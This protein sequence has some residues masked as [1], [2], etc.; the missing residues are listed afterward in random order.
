MRIR[1]KFFRLMDAAAGDGGDGGGA[2]GGEQGGAAA[3][4]GATGGEQGGEGGAASALGTGGDGGAAPVWTLESVPEKYRVK[5]EDGSLDVEATFG[6]VDQAR[7]A[8]EK[9]IGS[10]DIPP[11]DFSGYK[12]PEVPEAFKDVKFE[13]GDFAKKAHAMG[14]TQKQYEGVM[15]EYLTLLPQIVGNDQQAAASE[16][17]STLRETWGDQADANFSKAFRAAN[18]LAEAAGLTYPE[19]EKALGNNPVAL[20]LLAAVGG[21]MSEDKTPNAANGGGGAPG[22]NID[23]ALA[24]PAYLNAKHPDHK[25]VSA[26]VKA[27]YDKQQG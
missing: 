10:G 12:M 4:N 20:R 21:E 5:K 1:N 22:F 14:L 18:A 16:V 2:G 7:S 13:T 27:Y 19:I 25:K 6:K 23:A 24:S 8:A 15:S 26:D 17:V 3:D 9:R 11:K